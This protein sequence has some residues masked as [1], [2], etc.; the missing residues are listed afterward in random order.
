MAYGFMGVGLILGA[1]IVSKAS[2]WRAVRGRSK[3]QGA[4]GR[5]A[6]PARAQWI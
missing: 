6:S 2:G 5:S 4:V 1:L 3:K